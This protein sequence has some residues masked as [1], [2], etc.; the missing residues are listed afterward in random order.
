MGTSDLDGPDWRMGRGF[1]DGRKIWRTLSVPMREKRLLR[2]QLRPD[3]DVV[4][5]ADAL[6]AAG[7]QVMTEDVS[8]G[9]SI[10]RGYMMVGKLVPAANGR[11]R[12]EVHR[13]VNMGTGTGSTFEIS[14]ELAARA[15]AHPREPD[16][17]IMGI[18]HTH[19]DPF[20]AE[21][22]SGDLEFQRR[23][24]EDQFGMVLKV[25]ADGGGAVSVFDGD[26]HIDYSVEGAGGSQAFRAEER[27]TLDLQRL[28]S[29]PDPQVPEGL[30]A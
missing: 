14:P 21:P 15:T 9:R 29:T 16:E 4:L 3:I 22:S 13:V 27:G 30:A 10:E 2:R 24:A 26:G 19:P 12:A 7:N 18:A 1:V 28:R 23:Y 5:S 11:V 20:I 25:N 8:C 17:K 6:Q